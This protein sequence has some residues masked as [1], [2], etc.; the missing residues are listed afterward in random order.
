MKTV[1]MNCLDRVPGC[2]G[3]CPA[4]LEYREKRQQELELRWCKNELCL[5]CGD[6]KQS[7]LGACDGCRWY[8]M[9]EEVI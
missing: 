5:K 7:Y 1:C 3:N 8:V 4:Y 6:Y 2:H 9:N